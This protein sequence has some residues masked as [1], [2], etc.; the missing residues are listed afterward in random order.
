MSIFIINI[1]KT[2]IPPAGVGGIGRTS[3]SS[4]FIRAKIAIEQILTSACRLN[5]EAFVTVSI[6][7]DN[8]HVGV[9]RAN[10]DTVFLA[11]N[12]QLLEE[13]NVSV[14]E[15]F[16][17]PRPFRPQC[18]C[19][20]GCSRYSQLTYQSYLSQVRPIDGFQSN[21]IPQPKWFANLLQG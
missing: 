14:L 9:G 20:Q 18:F 12:F 16:F 17:L 7:D 21:R 13:G 10:P 11:K 5:T 8:L 3:L 19:H 2:K 6:I 1:L 15:A 4:R